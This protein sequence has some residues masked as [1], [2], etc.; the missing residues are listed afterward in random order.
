MVKLSEDY[1]ERMI[2]CSLKMNKSWP[3]R[4]SVLTHKRTHFSKESFSRDVYRALIWDGAPK[5]MNFSDIPVVKST[6]RKD[7]RSFTSAE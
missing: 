4:V 7:R 5:K 6:K 2:L 1:T 3:L